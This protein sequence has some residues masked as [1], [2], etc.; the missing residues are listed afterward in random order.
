MM[1]DEDELAFTLATANVIDRSLAKLPIVPCEFCG[2]EIVYVD[3]LALTRLAFLGSVAGEPTI[4]P[5]WNEVHEYTADGEYA[6]TLREHTH[7][8]CAARMCGDELGPEDEP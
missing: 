1:T 5:T 7:E 3:L 4:G 8:R 2:F 6:L